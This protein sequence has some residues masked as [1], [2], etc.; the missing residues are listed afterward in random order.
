MEVSARMLPWNVV[1]VPRVA[2]LVT[3]Q[4]TL[5]GEAPLVRIIW[6]A[7]LVM[8]AEPIWKTKIAFGLFWALRVKLPP[9]VSKLVALYTPGRSVWPPPIKP[10]MAVTGVS[11]AATL[12]ALV[13][14]DWAWAAT[15]SA[16]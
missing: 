1:P 14:S 13:R 8:S 10:G 4:N 3:C 15:A 2:E 5:Q 11:P 6:V 12:Y 16:E 7:E 9:T